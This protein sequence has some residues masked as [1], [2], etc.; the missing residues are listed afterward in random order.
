MF[1]KV[2]NINSRES[3]EV[4]MVSDYTSDTQRNFSVEKKKKKA[5]F[6]PKA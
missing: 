1:K 5:G 3:K 2:L 6:I 4:M